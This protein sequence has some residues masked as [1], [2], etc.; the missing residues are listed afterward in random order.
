MVVGG[1]L[2]CGKI[3]NNS[4]DSLNTRNLLV[5]IRRIAIAPL[6]VVSAAHLS[7]SAADVRSAAE[8]EKSSQFDTSIISIIR[9]YVS[10]HSGSKLFSG[11]KKF[12][13]S[14]EE[15]ERE[16]RKK[17]RRREKRHEKREGRQE[18]RE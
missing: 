9:R 4:R 1:R 11:R 12:A 7:L 18:K 14:E 3:F 2:A 10:L 13:G 6:I 8:S 15:E 17:K 5:H 16:R